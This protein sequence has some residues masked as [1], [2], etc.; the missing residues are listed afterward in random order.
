MSTAVLDASIIDEVRDAL[1]DAAYRGFATTLLAE[2]EALV[3]QLDR[4]LTSAEYE[5]LAQTA[6]RSAGSAVSVGAVAI[7]SLLK[8]IEDQA[9]QPD[10]AARLPAL[11]QALPGKLSETRAAVAALIGPV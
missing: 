6:H 11:V 10:A 7:H 8:Q 4:L 1:G 5:A 2:I 9:R 3:P